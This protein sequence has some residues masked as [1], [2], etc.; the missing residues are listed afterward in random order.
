MWRNER[1]AKETLGL[2]YEAV[3]ITE[4]NLQAKS[5]TQHYWFFFSQAKVSLYDKYNGR[6]Y[7]MSEYG[8]TSPNDILLRISKTSNGK[9]N[10]I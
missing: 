1:K 8:E 4:V 6:N 9:E 3:G 5:Y 7:R 10:F 2:S